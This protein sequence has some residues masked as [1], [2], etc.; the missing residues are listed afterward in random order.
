MNDKDKIEVVG[1]EVEPLSLS[2]A[3]IQARSASAV[4][5]LYSSEP[6]EFQK[7]EEGKDI[8]FSYSL[9]IMP[10]DTLFSDRLKPYI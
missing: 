3:S 6:K 9:S 2:A 10:S 8:D 5:H 7:L 4:E 1:F